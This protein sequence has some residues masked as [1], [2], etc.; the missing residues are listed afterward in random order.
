MPPHTRQAPLLA[1]HTS[2]TVNTS[3]MT[4]SG[5]F[6]RGCSQSTLF[7][8][9]GVGSSRKPLAS[10]IL[11]Q[12]FLQVG[13]HTFFVLRSASKY[14]PHTRQARLRR[15]LTGFPVLRILS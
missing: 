5:S 13:P 3:A 1:C 11:C 4:S 10:R 9:L 2:P 14:R 15:C 8:G 6:S 7:N 12:R